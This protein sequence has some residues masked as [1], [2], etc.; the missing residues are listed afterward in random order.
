MPGHPVL[1]VFPTAAAPLTLQAI[2]QPCGDWWDFAP[3]L[4]NNPSGTKNIG[5]SALFG[6]CREKPESRS[7]LENLI[8]ALQKERSVEDQE[9]VVLGILYV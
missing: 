4:H 8:L 3:W 6:S 1:R 7:G 2:P 9:Y 5:T